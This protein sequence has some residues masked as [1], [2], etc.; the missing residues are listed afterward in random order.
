MFLMHSIV[1][2]LILTQRNVRIR[3]NFQLVIAKY[4][5]LVYCEIL[6]K[7][8]IDQ[9]SNTKPETGIKTTEKICHPSLEYGSIIRFNNIRPESKEKSNRLCMRTNRIA[10][11]HIAPQSQRQGGRR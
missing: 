4:Y 2:S 8:F 7:V 6:D 10:R 11:L 1:H 5:I 9:A 3:Y